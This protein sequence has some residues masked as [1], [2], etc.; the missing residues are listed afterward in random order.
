MSKADASHLSGRDYSVGINTLLLKEAKG[1]TKTDKLVLFSIKNIYVVI[2][3]A[4]RMLL[5]KKKRDR[6]Y[7]GRGISFKSFL[8]KSVKL[9]R[10]NNSLLSVHL[11]KFGCHAYC[12][13][14]D[15][16]DDFV[17]MTQHEDFLLERFSCKKGDIVVDVGAHI[18]QY[19]ITSSAR[20]GPNGKVVA[21]EADPANF[22]MLKLNINLN[23][24]TNV[25]PINYAVSSKE[26]KIKLYLPS[27]ESGFTKYNTINTDRARTEKDKFIQ[28]NAN[29]L[30]NL[31]QQNGISH[32]DVNWIKI[33]VE[34]AEYEVLKGATS[35]LSKSK[36]IALLIE[37]HNLAG[38]NNF[39][40]QIVEFPCSYGFKIEFEKKYES[41][42]R[43][44]IV[45]KSKD[46]ANVGLK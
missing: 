19:T 8:Y 45:R 5:G 6:L 27:Q 15:S 37:V 41:G 35:I 20:L 30:D 38:G 18:G 7:I 23:Q 43:H 3:V 11:P 26:E 22:E 4:A 17:I 2:R 40:T 9:L 29:T 46:T 32:E 39:Y 31:L 24:F 21:I 25:L 13:V 34:G 12:R 10:M 36:D 16:F 28:V 33:D 14:G 44:I 42:E 1:V